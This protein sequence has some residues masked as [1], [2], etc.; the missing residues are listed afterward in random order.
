MNL[1]G[2]VLAAGASTRF[3]ARHKLLEAVGGC[4]V[5]AHTLTAV[6][7][8]RLDPVLLVVGHRAA[9]VVAGLGELAHHPKLVVIPNPMRESG[10][11]SSLRAGLEGLPPDV[12]ACLAMPGDLPLMT[13]D[14]IDAVV[15]A[16]CRTRALCFPVYNQRKGHPVA[17]PRSWFARLGQLEGDRSA[18]DLIQDAWDTA[19]RLPRQ[20]A[21]TQF[22]VNT[23]QDLKRLKR[24]LA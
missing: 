19:T 8:A 23:P 21:R 18:H 2:I 6:L 10:R 9:E 11:A 20:D 12:P 7:G 4:T 5:L 14:L 16:A 24:W 15:E 3:G 17:F 1:P 13:R 22:N